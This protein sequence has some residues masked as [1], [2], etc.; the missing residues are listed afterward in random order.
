MGLDN[1]KHDVCLTIL[2]DGPMGSS[3]W[4]SPLVVLLVECGVALPLHI[5]VHPAEACVLQAPAFT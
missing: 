3:C 4:V 2:L 5:A 1:V